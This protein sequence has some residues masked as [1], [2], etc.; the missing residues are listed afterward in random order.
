[1]FCEICDNIYH[2]FC[3]ESGTPIN[4]EEPWFCPSCA[5]VDQPKNIKQKISHNKPVT[6]SKNSFTIDTPDP[7][8]KTEDLKIKS[9][10]KG[11]K[12]K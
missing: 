10:K 11:G 5:S 2:S 7:V 6:R 12:H 1:M 4:T 9:P 8:P 3:L